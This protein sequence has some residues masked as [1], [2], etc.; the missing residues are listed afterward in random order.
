MKAL[1]TVFLWGLVLLILASAIVPYT[2]SSFFPYFQIL[3]S[4]D[5]VFWMAALA[6]LILASLKWRNPVLPAFTFILATALLVWRGYGTMPA[7]DAISANE[8]SVLCLN[9]GQFNNDTIDVQSTIE[10]IKRHDPD[11][12]CL[13]EFGLYY[14]W[15]DVASVA[16]DFSEKTGLSH[17]D[18]TPHPGNIF[19]T[20]VFSK[21]PILSVD[22]VFNMLSATNEA[23]SYVIDVNGME[24]KLMNMHLQSY[25]ILGPKH[26]G[27]SLDDDLVETLSRRRSQV[28]ILVKHKADIVVG[29]L[30][31]SVGSF[32][33]ETVAN[34]WRD[35]QRAF[36]MGLLPTHAYVPTRLDYI[37]TRKRMRPISFERL[38]GFPSD[39]YGLL[40]T[41][42]I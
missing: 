23:K 28:R 42:A 40:A 27:N 22:T 31:A 29:D 6:L 25:N 33:Y 5:V 16:K 37:F 7:F 39:H 24:V 12:L 1:I 8:I 36:G 15:P 41:L 11:I 3:P 17:Y 30:N 9:V 20:A 35:V 32:Y 4:F 26:G 13:Q 10:E 38:T 14:T 18:F 19:G 21:F 34:K 2:H